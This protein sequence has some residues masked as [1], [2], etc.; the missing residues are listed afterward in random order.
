MSKGHEIALNA[1]VALLIAVVGFLSHEVFNNA[2]DIA[3][4]R[5][6]LQEQRELRAQG[7]TRLSKVEDFVSQHLQKVLD[8]RFAEVNQ[9]LESLTGTVTAIGKQTTRLETQ[10]ERMER[11]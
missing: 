3:G 9:K 8:Q 10:I 5:A 11:K 2:R 6:E 1:I 4:L 7:Y